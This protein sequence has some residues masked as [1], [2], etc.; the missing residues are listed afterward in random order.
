M[1]KR[2]KYNNI[3]IEYKGE[4]FD[5]KAEATRAWELDML[6]QAGKIAAWQRQ[7]TFKLG[8]PENRYRIDF[9]VWDADGRTWAEDVKGVDTPAFLKNVRLWRKYGPCTLRVVRRG[10]AV[11]VITPDFMKGTA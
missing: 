7:V 10:G 3:R 5:S 8:C 2:S 9:L 1:P 4:M 6:M 11:E